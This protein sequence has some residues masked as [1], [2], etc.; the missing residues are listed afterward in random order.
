MAKPP[1]PPPPRQGTLDWLNSLNAR[2]VTEHTEEVASA[3]RRSSVN[4]EIADLLWKRVGVEG[5]VAAASVGQVRDL[6][7][8]LSGL[9]AKEKAEVARTW[10][11]LPGQ[12]RKL[13]H[14]AETAAHLRKVLSSLGQRCTTRVVRVPTAG[15]AGRNSTNSVRKLR[16]NWHEN[17]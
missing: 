9:H 14:P 11:N 1:E 17:E 4:R 12:L 3:E 6:L 16:L 5:K 7:K 2:V 8:R 10:P 15:S 13:S